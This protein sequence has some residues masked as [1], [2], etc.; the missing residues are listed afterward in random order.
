[1]VPA[2]R[3]AGLA[4]ADREQ[5]PVTRHGL[6]SLHLAAHAL[7]ARFFFD[8]DDTIRAACLSAFKSEIGEGKADAFFACIDKTLTVDE[9]RKLV[10]RSK[11][12]FDALRTAL[13]QPDLADWKIR[14]MLMAE[15]L[16]EMPTTRGTRRGPWIEFPEHTMGE[17]KRAVCCLTDRSDYGIVRMAIIHSRASLHAI[18]RYFMQIRLSRLLQL[19]CRREGQEDA[20]DAHRPGEGPHPHR[21]FSI[22]A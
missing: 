11:K 22:S 17:P 3:A 7:L 19:R 9:R 18:D 6:A 20:G 14:V 10:A 5:R 2:P 12:R 8:L 16:R 4:R 13:N 21:G 15:K 1:M